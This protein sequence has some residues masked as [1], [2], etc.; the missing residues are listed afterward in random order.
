MLLPLLDEK[1]NAAQEAVQSVLR[2][3]PKLRQEELASGWREGLRAAR[4]HFGAVPRQNHF[5]RDL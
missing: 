2:A 4:R 3:E 5:T 1:F